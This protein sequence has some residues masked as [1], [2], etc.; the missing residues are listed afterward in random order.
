MSNL[1]A[2]S[3]LKL[4]VSL[5]KIKHS[6]AHAVLF[7]VCQRGFFEMGDSIDLTDEEVLSVKITSKGPILK[8]SN[9]PKHFSIEH[10]ID[11]FVTFG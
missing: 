4:A 6:S 3:S 8:R 5:E 1:P 9:T 10:F 7:E 2:S 11:S